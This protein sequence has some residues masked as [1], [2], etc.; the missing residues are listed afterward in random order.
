MSA[1]DRVLFRSLNMANAALAMPAVRGATIF[2]YGRHCALWISAFEILAHH[3]SGRNRAD[4]SAVLDLLERKP[5][6]FRQLNARRYTVR[7]RGRTRR[8]SLACK[9]YAL[10]YQVRNDFLHGNPVDNRTL[11]LKE[12]GRFIGHF[13]PLLYRCALRNYLDLHYVPPAPLEDQQAREAAQL[14]AHDYEE[15]QFDVEQALLLARVSPAA[16]VMLP[17]AHRVHRDRPRPHRDH[18]PRMRASL[19]S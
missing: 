13:A 5:H 15:P 11:L 17:R 7:H 18:R 12:S 3:D 4:L 10:L 8:T 1:F 16:H 6:W 14:A 2:D 19:S 9:L